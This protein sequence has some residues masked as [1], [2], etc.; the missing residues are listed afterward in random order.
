MSLPFLI[1]CLTTA[2][3]DPALHYALYRSEDLG[4]NWS[5]SDSGLPRDSRINALAATENSLLAGTDSGIFLTEDSGRTWQKSTLP[6]LTFPRVISLSAA[7]NYAFAGTEGAILSSTDGGRTWLTNQTF[8]RRIIRSLL[9]RDGAVYAGTDAGGVYKTTDLRTASSRWTQLSAGLPPN[10]QVL[11]LTS[12]ETQIFAG[13][14]AK[15]LYTW[16]EPAQKWL[17]LGADAEIKPLVLASNGK[18]LIAGHNP[19]GIYFSDDLGRTWSRWSVPP[20]DHAFPSLDSILNNPSHP[21]AALPALEAPIWEMSAGTE[22][23]LAGAGPA[24]YLSTDRART[25]TRATSGLPSNSPGIAFLIHKNLILAALHEK[26][27]TC[28]VPS[29]TKDQN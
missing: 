10:A 20:A 9:A 14:Y 6:G 13:L 3:A 16:N 29:Q 17:Q 18:T 4:R 2:L 23:A 8:P 22:I 15:G 7:G 24:I 11:A 19:G 1:F 28:I 21:P 12:I 5:K 27:P 25:W 26:Q